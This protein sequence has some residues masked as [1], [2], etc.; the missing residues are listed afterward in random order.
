M[1]YFERLGNSLIFRNNGE[2]L[3]INPWGENSLRVRA[4]IQE[5]I[6][7]TD[8]ALLPYEE[9][10]AEIVIGET[11]AT[12]RCGMLTAKLYVETNQGNCCIAYYNQKGELLLSEIENGGALR[13]RSRAYTP[14]LGGDFSL[15]V[16]F[17]G[18]DEHL[19]G[20]GQYQEE[21][22]DL[23][24]GVFELAHRNSQASVP[25][26]VSSKG[27]GFLWHNPAIGQVA[28]GKNCTEWKAQST[29]QM[30]Y[31]ITA[32]DSFQQISYQYAKATGF[33]PMMPEYGL[34]FWQC[35][36]RYWN[37]E[38]LLEVAREYHRRNIPVSVIVCDF[39]HWPKMGDYRFEEEFFPDPKAMVDELKQM[40]MELMVS[41]WP[42][43]DLLSENY[44]Y[45]RQQNML[46]R[47][48]M[49]EQIGMRFG[50]DNMFYD[51]TNPRARQF[52]W[53]KCKQNYAD[54]GVKL[55]W[56][57]EA[58]PEYSEYDFANFRYHAGPNLQVGNVYP[59]C[60]S[61]G[62]YDGQKQMGQDDIVNLVRC[63]WAGSQ[64]YGA[65]VWSG[66]IHSDW[67]SFRKQLCAGLNMGMAGIPWWTT[68]IGG[69]YGGNPDDPAFRE[70]LAR[71][72][73]WA[74]FCPVMRLHGDRS[75]GQMI[76]R[77]D[78]S[79]NMHTGSFNE[80]WCFGEELTP[81][82]TDF[83]K[84][85]ERMRPYVRR[86][87]EEAHEKGTPVMRPMFYEFP[88][89]PA[90]YAIQDQYMFGPDALV[91]PVMEPGVSTRKVYLPK[92]A[93]WTEQHTGKVFD[94]GYTVEAQAPI[95]VI[96][97]FLKNGAQ[98]EG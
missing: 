48:E 21:Q 36:L 62:F 2:T 82:L 61:R 25:F 81:V 53:E 9:A 47:A 72:F 31:W 86:L 10:E 15:T 3:M 19:W 40:G 6:L 14:H 68:D 85:R 32:G 93:K 88:D 29:K 33:A 8:W 5:D 65:L 35:K 63:A 42:Q 97:V 60:Y 70:L 18:Q 71:W 91:A 74:V 75:P 26:V 78:G 11:E 87:M 44:G 28:F 95:H 94:G 12:I 52:V 90:C 89:D 22:L 59:Q 55:F 1:S 45:M 69:F 80:V 49:G 77:K 20:L 54:Y 56:L 27:Y 84:M 92:G 58:E 73:A 51:A 7:D 34:G 17:R 66:D 50:G 4:R 64:R 16:S 79:A 13:R 76:Y 39:F 98:I 41:V 83:I 37:Q 67:Q 38:Q 57:D 24:Y 46:V 23:K 43:V 30:D 96:P